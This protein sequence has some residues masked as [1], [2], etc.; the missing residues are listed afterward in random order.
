MT[1]SFIPDISLM[2]RRRA[3][4]HEDMWAK[5]KRMPAIFLV[6]DNNVIT[7]PNDNKFPKLP[8][9]SFDKKSRTH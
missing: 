8:G 7:G 1:S 3:H 5:K 9:R 2:Q 4:M 6:D